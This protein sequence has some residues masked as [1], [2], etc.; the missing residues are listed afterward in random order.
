MKLTVRSA[1][2]ILLLSFLITPVMA[3]DAP[4]K[5]AVVDVEVLVAAR[6]EAFAL[7]REAARRTLGERPYDVQIL[8]AI[9]LHQGAI[10]EMARRATGGGELSDVDT[11]TR[12]GATA[13][14]L[15]DRVRRQRQPAWPLNE[16]PV[17]GHCRADQ[18]ENSEYVQDKLV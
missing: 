13:A 2:S 9:V 10:A 5:I 7:V 1:A 12:D 17:S 4:L 6:R 16:T 11:R 15:Q 8:G 3:Q 14:V 18:E